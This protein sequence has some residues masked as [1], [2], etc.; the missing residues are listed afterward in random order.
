MQQKTYSFPKVGGGEI[1]KTLAGPTL[2]R[3]AD[4]LELFGVKSF[5]ELRT[6][7]GQ[8]SYAFFV[9]ETGRDQGKLKNTLDV[10]LI[11]GNADIDFEV[12]DL[13]ASDEVIQD[14]FEQ[15]SKTLQSR[16]RL[17]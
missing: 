15:R 17:S 5:N 12:L 8:L 2:R 13:R 6:D 14:F 7:D 9:L 10:C 4:F 3:T 11:E 16:M 1:S